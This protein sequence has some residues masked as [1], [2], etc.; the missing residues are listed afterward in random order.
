MLDVHNRDTINHIIENNVNNLNEFA[1][2]GQLRYYYKDED[3]DIK[4]MV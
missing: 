1:W 2:Q 3:D 4:I